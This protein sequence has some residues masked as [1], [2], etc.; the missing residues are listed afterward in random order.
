MVKVTK[1]VNTADASAKACFFAQGNTEK[2]KA[3]VVHNLSALRQGSTKNLVP[4]SAALG[5]RIFSHDVNQAYLHS[6]DKLSREIFVRPRAWDAR[7]F[8]VRDE[9]ILQVLLPLYGL[10][11]A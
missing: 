2:A 10:P 6:K 8:S 11:D 4:T 3:F 9:E 1:R 5:L 7:Y